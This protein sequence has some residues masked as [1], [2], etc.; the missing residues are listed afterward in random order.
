MKREIKVVVLGVLG[1]LFA[2]LVIAFALQGTAFFLYKVFAPRQEAVRRDV[3]EQSKAYNEG[4][5]QELQNM[6]FQYAQADEGH[7]SALASL[8]LHRVADYDISKLDPDML[9]F[10]ERL[11]AE[12]LGGGR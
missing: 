1:G 3:F 6:A 12:R 10:V 8:I 11:R 7:K 2:M 9:N 5:R 4:M